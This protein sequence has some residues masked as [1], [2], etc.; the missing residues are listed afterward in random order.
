MKFVTDHLDEA[1]K[2]VMWSD[3][4]NSA[5]RVR[6]AKNTEYNPKKTIPTVNHGLALGVLFSQGDGTQSLEGAKHLEERR[7]EEWVNIPA[8]MCTNPVTNDKN[9]LTSALANKGF[10]TKY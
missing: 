9:H 2:K 1:W 7:G 6:R 5:G 8:E 4:L 3:E 10:S